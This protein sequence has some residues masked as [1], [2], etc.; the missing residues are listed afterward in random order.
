MTRI[1]F[2]SKKKKEK[3]ERNSYPCCEVD[4]GQAFIISNSEAVGVGGE[5]RNLFLIFSLLT[6]V[7]NLFLFLN[8]KTYLMHSLMHPTKTRRHPLLF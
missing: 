3:K 2:A 7:I 6:A 4:V 5:H 8:I 1:T